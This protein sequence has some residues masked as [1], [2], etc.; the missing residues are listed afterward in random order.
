MLVFPII[1]STLFKFAFANILSGEQMETIDVAIVTDGV[2]EDSTQLTVYKEVFSADTFQTAYLT[3]KEAK[4]QLKAEK[5]DGYILLSE[6]KLVV[7]GKGYAQTVLKEVIDY[8]NQEMS[9][10]TKIYIANQGE[11]SQ[12]FTAAIQETKSYITD[13]KVSNQEPNTIVVY[14]YTV[15]AMTAFF[16]ASGGILEVMSI[17]ANQSS[18]ALRVNLAPVSKLQVFAPSALAAEVLQF[19]VMVIVI[20]YIR[21]VL[22]ID[23]GNRYGLIL[24]NTFVGSICGMAFGAMIGA[25]VKKNENFKTGVCMGFTMFCCFLAGMMGSDIKYMIK[26]AVPLVDR[27]NPVNLITE[28]YYKL[29]YY[30]ALGSFWQNIAILLVMTGICLGIT[31]GILRRQ[32]YDSL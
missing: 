6:P 4:A 11:V 21:F 25:I 12:E 28:G 22:G 23:F 16:A 1:L 18:V 5:I 14:F 27:L 29:Y 7:D 31:L 2:A 13:L 30:D 17:Q 10:I 26:K 3:E 9:A 20:L 24:L 19:G 32:R 15:L 8:I